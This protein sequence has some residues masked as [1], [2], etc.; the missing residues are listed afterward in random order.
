[1]GKGSRWRPIARLLCSGWAPFALRQPPVG[2]HVCPNTTV[3]IRAMGGVEVRV[4]LQWMALGL[5]FVLVGGICLWYEVMIPSAWY[6][7]SFAVALGDVDGD[8]D[9]DAFVG[10]LGPDSVWLNDGAFADSGQR[11]GD[12]W[13]QGGRGGSPRSGGTMARVGLCHGPHPGSR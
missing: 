3:F 12:D 1:M 2:V 7:R 11:L 6:A 5:A 8:G 10:S 9:L 4:R 13:T